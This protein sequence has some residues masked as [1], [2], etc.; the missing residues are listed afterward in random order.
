MQEILQID[1][2]FWLGWVDEVVGMAEMGSPGRLVY[3]FC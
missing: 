3:D 1:Y 2:G